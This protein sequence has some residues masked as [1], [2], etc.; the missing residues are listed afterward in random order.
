MSLMK[1]DPLEIPIQTQ[2]GVFHAPRWGYPILSNFVQWL[3]KEAE[4]NPN[5]K[6]RLCLHPNPNEI[7]Q[8]TFIA[9]VAP[10]QDRSHTHPYKPEI[11]IPILGKAILTIQEDSKSAPNLVTL[12]SENSLPISIQANAVHSLKIVTSHFV[13]LEIGNGPFTSNSTCYV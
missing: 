5:N 2:P 6:A 4:K 8:V 9:L 11:M 3:I 10:Y 7:T 12:D 1:Q 13:F